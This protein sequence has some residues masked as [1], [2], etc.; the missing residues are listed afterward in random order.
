VV[1]RRQVWGPAG[2]VSFTFELSAGARP[3]SHLLDQGTAV[4]CRQPTR[5]T[6]GEAA[7]VHHCVHMG[8]TL[9]ATFWLGRSASAFRRAM[10]SSDMWIPRDFV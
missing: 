8:W 10:F 6:E 4:C 3:R 7:G 1:A 9:G 2:H 5:R